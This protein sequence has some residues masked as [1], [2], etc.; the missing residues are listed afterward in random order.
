LVESQA[1]NVNFETGKNGWVS[2][3]TVKVVFSPPKT[4]GNDAPHNTRRSHSTL[5]YKELLFRAHKYLWIGK[6]QE[7]SVIRQ[8]LFSPSAAALGALTGII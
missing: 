1:E 5:F 7:L 6:R 4:K 3:S 8:F 2:K